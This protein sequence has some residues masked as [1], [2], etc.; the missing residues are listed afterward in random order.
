MEK[1]SLK[2]GE[3]KYELESLLNESSSGD[4]QH[5][6]DEEEE[7]DD[8]TAVDSDLIIN[9]DEQDDLES[10]NQVDQKQQLLDF[11]E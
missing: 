11:I 2:K 4:E 9:F 7:E 3:S 6:S 8:E 1:S 5:S 10:G